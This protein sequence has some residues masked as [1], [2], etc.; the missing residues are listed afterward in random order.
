MTEGMT[1]DVD[2]EAERIGVR[3][4]LPP[5]QHAAWR[6]AADDLGCSVTA[7]LVAMTPHLGAI[8]RRH[9]AIGRNALAFDAENRKRPK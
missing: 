8:V 5:D 9:P 2:L 3:A 1:F 7:L 6:K 4:R